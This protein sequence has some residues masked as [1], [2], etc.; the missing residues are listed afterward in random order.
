MADIRLFSGWEPAWWRAF[1]AVGVSARFDMRQ[2]NSPV[3]GGL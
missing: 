1:G 2:W 3:G